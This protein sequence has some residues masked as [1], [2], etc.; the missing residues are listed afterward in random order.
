MTGTTAIKTGGAFRRL[1]AQFIGLAIATLAIIALAACG[2]DP[3]PT[4]T[5]VPPT[6]TPAPEASQEGAPPTAEAPAEMP[7]PI[8]EGVKTGG[9]LTVTLVSENNTLDP[10]WSLG[11]AAHPHHPADVRQPADDPAGTSP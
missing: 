8:P 1:T 7:D 3:T 11:T 4:P 10:A 6:P 9:R 5:A 2:D